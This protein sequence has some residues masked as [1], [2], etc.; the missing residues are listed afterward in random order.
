MEGI[1][2]W[3]WL[4]FSVFPMS[5]PPPPTHPRN[6]PFNTISVLSSSCLI[7]L[8]ITRLQRSENVNDAP[9]Q[10]TCRSPL[11]TF[12][13][14]NKILQNMVTN[15]SPT[16]QVTWEYSFGFQ[17]ELPCSFG[18]VYETDLTYTIG[19]KKKKSYKSA[20]QACGESMNPNRKGL[21]QVTVG[22]ALISSVCLRVYPNF[23]FSTP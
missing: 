14:S 21:R 7:Y 8:P 2:V 18:V 17:S 23:E 20:N 11:T 16:Q 10:T 3:N 12:I 5:P 22:L 13:S 6:I 9:S 19:K 15:V 4:W 1:L